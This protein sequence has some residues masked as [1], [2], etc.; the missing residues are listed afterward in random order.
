MKDVVVV[1]GM[2]ESDRPLRAAWARGS[3]SSLQT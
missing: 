2:A 1:I 3:T